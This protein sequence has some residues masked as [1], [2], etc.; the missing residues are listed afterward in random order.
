MTPFYQ[1]TVIISETAVMGEKFSLK[2]NDYLVNVT[3]KFSVLRNED[4]FSDVTLV[5]SD[6]RQVSAHKVVLS[7]SS[8]YFKTILQN[9]NKSKD[10]MLCLE[11]ISH[12]ELNNML[13]Y[14]YNGEVNIE[15]DQLDRFLKIAQ[16][17]QLEGL[18]SDESG[19]LE[20]EDTQSYVVKNANKLQP[21]S[22]TENVDHEKK[23]AQ[24]S[25][26]EHFKISSEEFQSVE[27]LDE[28]LK[29]NLCRVD[30]DG[31]KKWQC[32][33]C[34]KVSRDLH[35]AKEHVEFHFEGLS[36]LCQDCD[37]TFRSRNALRQHKARHCNGKLISGPGRH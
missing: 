7:S 32:I 1:I 13:D 22:K 12:E 17:F 25:V 27:E 2:W 26:K 21:L 30:V 35:N 20:A 16:R 28:K 31:T 14:V 33:I 15:Q 24:N 4:E 11:N 37:K 6:K 23:I 5:S 10:I 29:E 8:D 3:K 9:N 19:E 36:F 34:N 18:I